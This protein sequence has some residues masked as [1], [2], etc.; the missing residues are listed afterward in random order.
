MENDKV[1][2]FLRHSVLC[3]RYSIVEFSRV[4]VVGVNSNCRR[5]RLN[6]YD[7]C[8]SHVRRRYD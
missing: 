7:W 1:G 4:S 6:Y 8:G 3:R 5:D 2:R